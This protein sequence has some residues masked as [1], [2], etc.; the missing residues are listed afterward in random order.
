[1]KTE[2]KKILATLE[3]QRDDILSKEIVY[4]L[5]IEIRIANSNITLLKYLLG[6]KPRRNVYKPLSIRKMMHDMKNEQLGKKI[7]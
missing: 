3:T 4:E 1:M 7:K 5:E 6:F 2:I